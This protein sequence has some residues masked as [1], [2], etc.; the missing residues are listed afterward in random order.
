MTDSN[1]YSEKEVR[2]YHPK[3]VYAIESA[4]G[5]GM[6]RVLGGPYDSREEARDAH[7]DAPRL[8]K[9]NSPGF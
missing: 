8:K 5:W 3:G 4:E 2:K 7:P 9:V 6:I 1:V